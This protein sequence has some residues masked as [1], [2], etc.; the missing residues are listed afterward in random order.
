MF[1]IIDADEYF[2]SR[3]GGLVTFLNTRKLIYSIIYR[4]RLE[5]KV[6]THG[7]SSTRIYFLCVTINMIVT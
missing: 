6:N 1:L 5:Y 3:S 2:N 7:H 4:H